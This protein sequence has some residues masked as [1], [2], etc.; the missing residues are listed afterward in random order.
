[1]TMALRPIV[2]TADTFLPTEKQVF[3]AH[4]VDRLFVYDKL[5]AFSVCEPHT[6]TAFMLIFG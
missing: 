6:D 3:N 4:L 2:E 5:L 1:M